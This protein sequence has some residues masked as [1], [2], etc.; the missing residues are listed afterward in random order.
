MFI[1]LLP[2]SSLMTLKIFIIFILLTVF[3]SIIDRECLRILQKRNWKPDDN[4]IHF[5]SGV[6]LGVGLFN[7]VTY[8]VSLFWS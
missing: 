3:L 6:K 1:D 4:K 8:Y 7:L 2:L 5:E